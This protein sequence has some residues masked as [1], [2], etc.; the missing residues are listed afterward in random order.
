MSLY[1]FKY[2]PENPAVDLRAMRML[3][4]VDLKVPSEQVLAKWDAKMDSALK[5]IN[6]YEKMAGVKNSRVIR[7][8]G[9]DKTLW[10]FTGPAMWLKAPYLISM[11]TMLIRLGDKMLEFND[12]EELRAALKKQSET[13]NHEKPS[14]DNDSNY[15]GACW[16]KLDLIIRNRELLFGAKTNH[17]YTKA[18]IDISRFHNRSGIHSLCSYNTLDPKLHKEL[19]TLHAEA[20]KNG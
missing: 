2:G 5:I 17:I 9:T 18:D 16:D 1:S 10:L 3:V 4:R 19:R 8:I 12:N 11:Y 15:L 20:S 6:H 14:N 7:I 13:F